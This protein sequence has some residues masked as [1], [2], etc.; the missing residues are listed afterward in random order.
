[1]TNKEKI[2]KKI[3]G[4]KIIFTKFSIKD[5]DDELIEL[6]IRRL[7]AGELNTLLKDL[8]GGKTLEEI[9][10]DEAEMQKFLTELIK[11]LV[12]ADNVKL[13]DAIDDVLELD[14]LIYTQIANNV[15]NFLNF[16]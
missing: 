13:F 12:Y 8:S 5:I 11:A 2:K 3:Y 10:A 1:M 14:A 16:A 15:M 7:K 6:Q 4:D 9:Q